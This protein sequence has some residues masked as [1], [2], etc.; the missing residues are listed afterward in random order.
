MGS[1]A[2][3]VPIDKG[4]TDHL[5]DHLE[6]TIHGAEAE[7]HHNHVRGRGLTHARFYH[8]TVPQEMLIVYLEGPDLENAL[9]EM[10]GSRGAPEEA[11][12][13]LIANLGEHTPGTFISASKLVMDWHHEEGHRHKPAKRK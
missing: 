11:W 10:R 12:A 6:E 8:Q 13:K 3:A 2:F 4:K 7:A 5:F 1:I 9:K